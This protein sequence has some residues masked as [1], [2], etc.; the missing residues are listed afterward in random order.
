MIKVFICEDIKNHRDKISNII[1][2]II[3]IENLDMETAVVTGNPDDILEYVKS[4][5]Y[6]GLYFLDVDLNTRINGIQLAEEIREYDP[7]GF[8]IFITTHS[9]MSYLTFIYK[10]E[11][12][13]YI[14]KDNFND[15]KNRVQQCILNANKKYTLNSNEKQKIFTIKSGDKIIN[16]KLSEILFFETSST[17]HKIVINTIDRRIEFYAQMKDVENIVDKRFFRCHKSFIVNKDNIKEI[18]KKSSMLRMINNQECL[19]SAR[20]IKLLLN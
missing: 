4:N 14:I 18:D 20:K 19:I 11:A 5:K 1:D 13:D 16:I 9:E 10:V 8:I 7:E 2:D 17:I 15:I 3:M 12:M 6:T